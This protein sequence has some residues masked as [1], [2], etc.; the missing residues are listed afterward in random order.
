MPTPEQMASV[1]DAIEQLEADQP[2]RRPWPDMTRSEKSAELAEIEWAGFSRREEMAVIGRIIAGEP[3]DQWMV[4]I[5]QSQH[6]DGDRPL[7]PDEITLLADEIRHDEFAARVRDYG[8]EDAATHEKRVREGAQTTRHLDTPEPNGWMDKLSI[9]DVSR[10]E[11]AAE[12]DR[13]KRDT[14]VELGEQ[15]AGW[16]YTRGDGGKPFHELPVADREVLVED[17]IDWSKYMER[18]LTFEDQSRVMHEAARDPFSRESPPSQEMGDKFRDTAN[19]LHYEVRMEETPTHH[20]A[21][22]GAAA[23][24]LPL[25]RVERQLS[26]YKAAHTPPKRDERLPNIINGLLDNSWHS[27][28][29]EAGKLRVL[30]GELDWT[31][32]SAKDK[33]TLLG[34][35]VDFS[36]LTRVQLNF[37]YDDIAFDH[38]REVDELPARR[39]FDSADRKSKDM[40]E[41]PMERAARQIGEDRPQLGGTQ[42][43]KLFRLESR[44]DWTG[45]NDK[46]KEALLRSA[47]DFEKITREGLNNVYTS[48]P[49]F[50]PD[51][52]DERPARRLFDNANYAQALAHADTSS[53]EEQMGR[54][55][56]TTKNLIGSI[57]LDAWPRV[58][59]IVDFGIDSQLHYEALYYPIRN[60]EIAPVVL[61]AAMGHG[62][63][64]TELTRTAHSN[65]HKDIRFH[66]AWDDLLG[67][68][69]QDEAKRELRHPAG[70][71]P[72]PAD[73]VERAGPSSPRPTSG[74]TPRHKL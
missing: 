47:V 36:K 72:S 20:P 68:E 19:P 5:G 44:I 9:D 48:L 65:P 45:I 63:K 71:I 22:E 54:V 74:Y 40:V 33:E 62:E 39:L 15:V 26:G 27:G 10:R 24:E 70:G 12:L 56:D 69:K 38:E 1:I 23:D 25:E 55:R 50:L 53:L 42:A 18:G 61:D 14:Y 11:L 66:T 73:L 21:T 59:A 4:G 49:S 8:E 32:V 60:A 3:S 28:L 30:E 51:E 57:L 64:L 16:N 35:E 41:T 52:V 58:G 2:L 6:P 34:R 29:T 17:Y 67:R 46:E 13:I 43:G 7:S 31:G 37:V